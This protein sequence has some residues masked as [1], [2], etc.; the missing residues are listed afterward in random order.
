MI[1]NGHRGREAEPSR[2]QRHE[3]QRAGDEAGQ[4][5]PRHDDRQRRHQRAKAELAMAKHQAADQRSKA[6]HR[7]RHTGQRVPQLSDHSDLHRHERR[8]Q[9]E[10]GDKGEKNLLAGQHPAK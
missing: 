8:D 7:D 9:S 3:L 5:R 1:E 2:E 4:C 6:R 10:I